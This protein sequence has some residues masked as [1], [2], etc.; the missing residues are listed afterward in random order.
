MSMRDTNNMLTIC[1]VL[2]QI[3]D[4]LQGPEHTHE[5]DLLAKA[6][7]M[8]KRMASKLREYNEKFESEWW[9]ANPDYKK[10]CIRK[11]STYL[12]GNP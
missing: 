10:E 9:E 5:R 3:N 4:G 7:H 6:E 11:E 1:E 12:V 8:A 2:R